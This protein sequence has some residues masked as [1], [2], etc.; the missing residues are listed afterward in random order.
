MA[1][2]RIKA[3]HRL[4]VDQGKRVLRLIPVPVGLLGSKNGEGI[5]QKASQPSEGVLHGLFLQPQ[6]RLIGQVPEGAAAAFPKN[7]AS[8]AWIFPSVGEGVISSSRIPKP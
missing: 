7:A 1:V 4:P 5:L 6:L 2:P 3:R 8:P